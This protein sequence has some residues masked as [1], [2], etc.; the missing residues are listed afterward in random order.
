MKME[1]ESTNIV[2]MYKRGTA[3]KNKWHPNKR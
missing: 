2:Y 3:N 1:E